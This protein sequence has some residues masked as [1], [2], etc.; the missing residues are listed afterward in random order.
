MPEKKRPSGY[1]AQC[2]CGKLI[3]A[4]DAKRTD[5][6]ETGKIIGKWLY[7]GCTVIPKFGC[8][9]SAHLEACEC[10]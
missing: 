1:V 2:Q 7:E 4:L 8:S 5:R 10:K 3:G 6:K 9:W